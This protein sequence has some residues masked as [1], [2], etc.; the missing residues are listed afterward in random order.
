MIIIA[1]NKM[2]GQKLAVPFGAEVFGHQVDQTIE[3]VEFGGGEAF[4]GHF[5]DV[6]GGCSNHVTQP[7]AVGG[8]L[9]QALSAMLRIRRALDDA[10]A[11]HAAQRDCHGRLLDTDQPRQLGLGSFLEMHEPGD[12]RIGA[13]QDAVL[14][15]ALGKA[16][17]DA[18]A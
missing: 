16:P 6:M 4:G 13:G 1:V 12:Y 2:H 11:F 7:A 9:D 8:Q 18:T 14:C 5:L 3:L 15:R 10:V 17:D